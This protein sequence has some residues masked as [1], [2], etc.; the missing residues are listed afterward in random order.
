MRL[1]QS[2]VPPAMPPRLGEHTLAVLRQAGLAEADIAALLRTGAA[3]D[4]LSPNDD[5]RKDPA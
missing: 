2:Q 4:A 5:N 3:R 1:Q